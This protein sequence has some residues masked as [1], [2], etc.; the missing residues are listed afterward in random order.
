MAASAFLAAPAPAAAQFVQRSGPAFTLDGRPW[1]FL[2]YNSYQLVSDRPSTACGRV[3]E[4]AV[5]DAVL[6][7]ARDSGATVVRTWFFQRYYRDAGDSYAPFDRILAKAAALGLKIIPVLVNHF[8]DCEPSAGRPKGE[9]FYAEGFRAPGWGYP[10]AFK[11][12][13]FQVASRYA[14]NPT[15]AFWQLVNEAETSSGG[16]CD[17]RLAPDGRTRSSRVLRSF[18]DEMTEHLKSADPHHL[19]SLGTIGSGQCGAEGAEY[20]YVHAGAVDLCEYHDYGDAIQPIP[21]DGFNRLR[22]RIDQ[23]HALDKPLVVGEAGIPADVGP[24]GTSLGAVDATTLRRRADLFDAKIRA[25]RDAGIDGYLIWEKIPDASNSAFNLD[26]GR[27]G[28]GPS[29]AG[30]EPVNDVMC[31]RAQEFT[32]VA[33]P[34]VTTLALNQTTFR[35]GDTLVLTMSAQSGACSTPGVADFYLAV[36]VPDGSAFVFDGTRWVPLFDGGQLSRAALR[37]YRERAAVAVA[38][39]AIVTGVL[40]EALPLGPYTFVAALVAPGADPID[41]ANWLGPPS[42]VTFTS[43]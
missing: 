6:R 3:L 9:A 33:P 36:V 1:R 11:D 30:A 2:G 27:F 10:L 15:I 5:V 43:P 34:A 24:L 4:D 37:P 17:R 39:E 32:G 28:V 25:A 35:A 7:D 14:A 22:Q 8:P 13:A 29:H 18:A 38:S 42:Q 20:Q 31:A 40:T 12:W 16:T 26:G 21:D 41:G 23:C 19:M